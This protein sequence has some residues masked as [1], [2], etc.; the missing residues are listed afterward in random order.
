MPKYSATC[1]H[2]GGS[3]VPGKQFLFEDEIAAEN[4][5]Y[6]NGMISEPGGIMVCKECHQIRRD[7]VRGRRCI[8]KDCENHAGEGSFV[9]DLCSP[10]H[11]FITTGGF[12]HSRACRNAI[13]KGAGFAR[14]FFEAAAAGKLA[15]LEHNRVRGEWDI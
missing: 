6:S 2:C 3:P 13:E 5:A 15:I 12:N 14:S 9:G 8:V 10:C 11:E 7:R 1:D 4:H